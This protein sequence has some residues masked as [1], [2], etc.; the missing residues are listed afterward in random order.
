MEPQEDSSCL[1]ATV[2]DLVNCTGT[3]PPPLLPPLAVDDGRN[4]VLL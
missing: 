1:V 4:D 2:G 3:P